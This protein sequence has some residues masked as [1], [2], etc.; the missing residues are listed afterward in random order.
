MHT[1]TRS[2][3]THIYTHTHIYLLIQCLLPKTTNTHKCVYN[4]YRSTHYSCTYGCACE[5]VILKQM[6][7]L[8]Q[9][10]TYVRSL[11]LSRTHT[12][13]QSIR[14]VA[15][16]AARTFVSSHQRAREDNDLAVILYNMSQ[17]C[18]LWRF[19]WSPSRRRSQGLCR[20]VTFSRRP[21]LPLIYWVPYAAAHSFYCQRQRFKKYKPS[22]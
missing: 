14:H 11:N 8:T 1:N 4:K 21:F 10:K 12:H 16:R 7:T 9:T 19:I 18:P 15:V 2:L 3:A 13:V 5:Q 17:C 22:Q 6:H 20:S